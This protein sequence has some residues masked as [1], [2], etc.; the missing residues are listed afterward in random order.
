MSSR[1]IN[2]HEW[3]TYHS[4]SMIAPQHLDSSGLIKRYG[5]NPLNG[6]LLVWR[7]RESK[8]QVKKRNRHTRLKWLVKQDS[9]TRAL[10]GTINILCELRKSPDQ[11]ST[12]KVWSLH[13]QTGN[14]KVKEIFQNKE[15]VAG[16]PCASLTALWRHLCV[17]ASSCRGIMSVR[18]LGYREPRGGRDI[19]IQHMGQGLQ[20]WQNCLCIW[21]TGS[22]WDKLSIWCGGSQLNC[23]SIGN[24]G[25]G[26]N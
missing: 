17:L 19:L 15:S 10:N 11:N 5:P 2:T 14:E 4:R 1:P 22:Q 20:S 16:N 25:I 23:L 7:G 26:G 12:S 3:R 9:N 6:K 24:P 8:M 21:R 18:S 13:N